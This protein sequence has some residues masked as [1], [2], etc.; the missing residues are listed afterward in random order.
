MIRMK[1][2]VG[3]RAIGVDGKGMVFAVFSEFY[4]YKHLRDVAFMVSPYQSSETWCL[5]PSGRRAKIVSLSPVRRD[6]P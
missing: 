5:F 1:R 6:Y 4:C 3:I 2:L